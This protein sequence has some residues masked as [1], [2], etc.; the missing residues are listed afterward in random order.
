M[1]GVGFSVAYPSSFVIK[2]LPYLKYQLT[3]TRV[4][5]HWQSHLHCH[6]SQ[7]LQ[8]GRCIRQERKLHNSGEIHQPPLW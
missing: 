7:V 8:E 3:I 4:K 5:R 2:R 1:S 6:Q